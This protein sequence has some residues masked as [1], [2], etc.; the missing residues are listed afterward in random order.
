MLNFAAFHKYTCLVDAPLSCGGDGSD[1]ELHL[2]LALLLLL[3]SLALALTRG[4]GVWESLAKKND[5]K[6]G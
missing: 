3:L 2:V 1:V 5:N 6:L 4:A